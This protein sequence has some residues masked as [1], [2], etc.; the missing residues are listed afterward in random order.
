MPLKSTIE[1]AHQDAEEG[2]SASTQAG[3]F[4]HERNR[5]YPKRRAWSAIGKA[6][7]CHRLIGS[8]PCGRE[9]AATEGRIA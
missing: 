4:V 3:E 2:K 6:G 8:S 5:S 9:T 1:K 7:D